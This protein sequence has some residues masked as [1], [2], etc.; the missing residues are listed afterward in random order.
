MLV[1]GRPDSIDGLFAFLVALA[2]AWLLVPLT[3]TA[4]RRLN[5]IDEPRERSLH[6]AP[7]PKLGGLAILCG[8]LVAGIL[9]LPSTSLT[10]AILGGAAVIAAVGV[11]DDAFDLPAGP[12]LLGQIV[13]AMIPVFSGV[14]VSDFTLPFVGGVQLDHMLFR[15]VIVLG[16][17]K[18]GHVLTVLSFVAVMNVINFIDGVDGLAAGVCVISAATFAIIA[19]SLD[20]PGAG[21]LAAATAGASLG[22]L[23]HGFPP[24]SSFMGDTGS[25]LLGYLLATVAV[26]GALKTN[27]VVALFFPLIVLAVP[28]LDGGFVIAK[29][30]KYR[31]PVYEADRWH[32][33]HRMAN[34]G[35]S[36]RRTLVYLYGWAS[37]LAGLALALRFVPYSDNHGHFNAA[38]TVV[39]VACGLTA[40]A[41]SV[42]LVVL[43]EILKL[44]RFRLRQLVGLRGPAAP[45]P[46]EV[47]A[48]VARELE[49]GSFAALNP[50]TGEFEVIDPDTGEFEAIEQG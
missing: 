1:D 6:E 5:A 29:R 22:F 31:R 36:Q 44:R 8:V 27:A 15:D 13:A 39:I 45:A 28:I 11:L 12:K 18:V 2:I 23:R 37:V 42:Y 20:R 30:L 14:W 41:A 43:L 46:E 32:F 25:N 4:A 34:I 38:W 16:N 35:F 19:L 3:E 9:F 40:L 21:V 7:T 49:T 47:D 10:R 50:E 24:A 48:G 17:V 26:L 33:H